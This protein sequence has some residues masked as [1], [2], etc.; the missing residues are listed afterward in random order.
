MPPKS[1]PPP[2]TRYRATVGIN[3]PDPRAT[4]AEHKAARD[5]GARCKELRVEAGDEF[6]PGHM[7]EKSLQNALAHG[8]VV[9]ADAADAAAAKAAA[10]KA[11]L[12]KAAAD[13]DLAAKMTA[14]TPAGSDTPPGPGPLPTEPDIRPVDPAKE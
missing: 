9:D 14:V 4:E 1:S 8:W 2:T 7:L 13:A 11:A 6:G 5:R 3:S 10:E 12:D